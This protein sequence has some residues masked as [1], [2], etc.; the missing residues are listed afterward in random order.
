MTKNVRV[1][2]AD[3]NIYVEVV[4]E[5]WDKEILQETKI[6]GFP[7]QISEVTIWDGKKLVIYER[8][9]AQTNG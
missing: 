5:V 9:K 2:N 6:L 3:T 7:T 1:E 4:V 8:P